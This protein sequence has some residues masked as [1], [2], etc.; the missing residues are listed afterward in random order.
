VTGRRVVWS[1]PELV[2]LLESFVPAADEVHFLQ[3]VKGPEGAL[4][5][6][7]AEQG[8]YA[9]RT[10]PT[11]TRQGIYATAPSGVLLAS[12]NSNSPKEMKAML[13]KALAK[14]AELPESERFLAEI[15]K[16]DRF[17]WESR[18]PADGLVLRV[19]A[20]DLPRSTPKKDPRWNLDTAWFTKEEM[21]SFTKEGA[22][23]EKLVRR[24]A[25]CH[26]LDFVRGQTYLYDEKHV[27]KAE[28]AVKVVR[29][30]GDIVELRYEGA[31]RTSAE[32]KWPVRGFADMNAPTD[33]KRGYDAKLLGRAKYDRAK[34]RF[35]EFELVAA[36]T[37]WGGTQYNARGDDLL[38]AP[39]GLAFTLAGDSPSARVAPAFIWGYGWK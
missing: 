28:L 32:G 39:L 30:D 31:T 8:H 2:K 17:R 20:R 3:T 4:F 18:Y 11:S 24:I 21:A 35:V 7:I 15:P 1:D 33:Q 27:E 10:Q 36:G 26:L 12:I 23:D 14:W 13:E 6:T 19:V 22:V 29:E 34:G 5:R 25:R 9:G 38:P 37:R 16:S